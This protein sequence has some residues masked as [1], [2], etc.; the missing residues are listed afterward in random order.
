MQINVEVFVLT[1]LLKLD[2]NFRHA[3]TILNG[4]SVS[5]KVSGESLLNDEGA[6]NSMLDGRI[7]N[8]VMGIS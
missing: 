7:D 3:M 1:S 5:A 8:T 4:T 6:S 2:A